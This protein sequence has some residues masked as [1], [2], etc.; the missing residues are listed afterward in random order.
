MRCNT[1]SNRAA[2]ATERTNVRIM[3]D[4]IKIIRYRKMKAGGCRGTYSSGFLEEF[5][6]LVGILRS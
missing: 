3:V 6:H 2:A 1:K 5:N 4:I